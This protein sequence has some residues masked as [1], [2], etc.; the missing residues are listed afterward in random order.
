MTEAERTPECDPVEPA[1][2]RPPQNVAGTFR[3]ML[4]VLGAE[5]ALTALMLGVYALLRRFTLRVA[6]GTALGTG[7]AVLNFCV[8]ILSLLRA[9]RKQ[10]AAAA[11]LT[12]RGQYVARMVALLVILVLALKFGPF[13]PLAT[14]LPLCF[15]RIALMISEPFRKKGEK[16]K[17]K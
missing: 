15:M 17:C 3:S 14:L 13:D 10:S 4:P 5:L 11:Q 7:V 12:V 8:M 9:E 16:S 1:G 2:E 6:L